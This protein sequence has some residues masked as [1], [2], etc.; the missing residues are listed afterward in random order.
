MTANYSLLRL[1]RFVRRLIAFLAEYL[2]GD[3]IGAKLVRAL[4]PLSV[5]QE[6][7]LIVRRDAYR[8]SWFEACQKLG[9]DYVL[10]VPHPLPAFEQGQTEKAT[11]TSASYTL[12]FNFVCGFCLSMS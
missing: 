5:L 11:L 2:A 6:R 4:N 7:S 12:L 1:P 3:T 9:V 8:Q 10:T